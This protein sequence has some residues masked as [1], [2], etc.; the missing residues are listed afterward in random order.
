[1]N[2]LS[3]ITQCFNEEGNVAE[4][5]ARVQAAMAQVPG[6]D[7]EHIFIDNASTDRTVEIIRQIAAGEPRVKLIVNARNFIGFFFFLDQHFNQGLFLIGKQID[8]FFV[9][10]H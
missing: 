4:L 3:V 8:Y 6:C 5:Q 1:M 7:Y 10:N 2:F 9:E